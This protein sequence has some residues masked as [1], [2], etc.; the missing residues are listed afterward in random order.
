MQTVRPLISRDLTLPLHCEI[1]YPRA[2]MTGAGV[3]VLVD[4]ADT[5]SNTASAQTMHNFMRAVRW[6]V[7]GRKK[8]NIIARTR[9]R[10]KSCAARGDR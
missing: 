4:V 5:V 6:S 8:K 1:D 10:E 3:C 2:A 9:T 7:I